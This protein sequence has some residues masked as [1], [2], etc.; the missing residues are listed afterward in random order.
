MN[1]KKLKDAIEVLKSD[2]G[3]ALISCDI[4]PTGVGTPLVGFNSN[5]Q[6]AALFDQVTGYIVKAL[7][8]SGF[9]LLDDYYMM[10]LKDNNLVVVLIFDDYQW[11]MLID[12]DKVNLGLL[13]SI[14]LPNAKKA[15]VEAIKG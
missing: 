4:Y 11:D 10:D 5:P 6:A 3:P 2:L 1:T 13:L 15:M 8:G 9:P 7:D 14:A 12:K